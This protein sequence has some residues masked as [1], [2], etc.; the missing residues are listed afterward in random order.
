MGKSTIS[1]AIFHGKLLV[2][3]RVYFLLVADVHPFIPMIPKKRTVTHVQFRGPRKGLF[4][5]R[6]AMASL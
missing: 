5:N 3:Q 6:L 1:M 4:E 2:H